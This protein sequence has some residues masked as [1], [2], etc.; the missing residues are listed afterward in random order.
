LVERP[1]ENSALGVFAWTPTASDNGTYQICFR[2]EDAY[3]YQTQPAC[4]TIRVG[5]GMCRSITLP[6]IATDTLV[7]VPPSPNL[8]SVT[9]TTP[10]YY[11]AASQLT[12]TG[13]NFVPLPVPKCTVRSVIPL[14]S[15]VVLIWNAPDRRHDNKRN[16]PDRK[17][18]RVRIAVD[19]LAA[20]QYIRG[21]DRYVWCP[22]GRNAV[23]LLLW[24]VLETRERKESHMN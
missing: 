11:G 5:S 18:G 14:Y 15:V 13:T 16:L 24:Y 6:I 4:V 7:I 19:E 20:D 21:R 2:A 3:A 1:G 12:V 10:Q 8:L 17:H 22:V 9:P 23:L